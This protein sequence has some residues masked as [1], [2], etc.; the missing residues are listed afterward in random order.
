MK[1]QELFRKKILLFLLAVSCL[2]ALLVLLYYPAGEHRPMDSLATVDSLIYRNFS[3]F[4]VPRHEISPVSIEVTDKF[5][6]K[7]Y[8]AHLPFGVSATHFHAELNRNLRPLQVRTIGYVDLPDAR[9][10]LHLVYADK[11]VR[12]LALYTA[13]PPTLP[14]ESD[15]AP[16]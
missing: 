2:A 14:T 6:R 5:T 13:S 12:T 10:N 1:K 3:D 11:V 16:L 7:H 15:T 4:E 9:M 8:R